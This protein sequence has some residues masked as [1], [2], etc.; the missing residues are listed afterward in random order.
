MVCPNYNNNGISRDTS[1]A[2]LST[3]FPSPGGHRYQYRG[4]FRNPQLA[5][6]SISGRDRLTY[7]RNCA[8]RRYSM[9]VTDE[10]FGQ[11]RV[12]THWPGAVSP[13]RPDKESSTRSPLD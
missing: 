6:S 8:E 12:H 1:T 10:Y 3:L 9:T 11:P 5:Y 4:R 7:A 13:I 2:D